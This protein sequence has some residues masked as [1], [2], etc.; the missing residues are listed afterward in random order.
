MG[1]FSTEGAVWW[2]FDTVERFMVD[3]FKGYGVPAKDAEICADVLITAD[4]RG[5]DSH[6]VGRLKPIYID[7]IKERQIDPVT[8]IDIV[9]EGPT[10][11]VLDANNGMGQVASVRG[12]QMAIDKAKKF[13]MGMVAVRNSNH[14]G[15]AGYYSLMA[16]EAGMIGFTGTNARP[17]IAPTF[18]VENMLGTNPLTFGIPTD[19]EFPF[20]IDCATSVTQRGKIEVYARQKKDMPPGWVIGSDGKTRTDSVQVLE[21]LVKGT[22]ALTPVGG[23]GEDGGGYKGYGWAAVVEILSSALQQGAFLKGLLGFE[24]GKRVPYKL[25]HFFMA[26]DINAFTDVPSFKKT[27]GEIC[28][29]LRNSKK[30]PG[31][32]RIWT[33]GEPEWD[34][35]QDRKVKG[36]PLDEVERAQ[37]EQ[38]QAELGLSKYTFPWKK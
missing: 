28:R 2:D 9:R 10:T 22:A 19:E 13:G 33:A 8:K 15:I 17:S 27:S 36:V 1:A 32:D 7:R 14:Y 23:I 38:L 12:M 26:I 37:F 24:N 31:Q 20:V 4:K 34:A 11:A 30:A 25:G 5:I 16:I 21:D 3:V 29:Q 35:W 6:G 18:G